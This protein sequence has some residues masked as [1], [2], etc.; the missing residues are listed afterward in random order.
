MTRADVGFGAV[1]Q[2]STFTSPLVADG[3]GPD[4]RRI[5]AVYHFHLP[6]VGECGG[7]SPGSSLQGEHQGLIFSTGF[8]AAV[9]SKSRQ[10]QLKEQNAVWGG[11]TPRH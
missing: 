2:R 5:S 1:S 4:Y 3:Y 6:C 9:D 11:A 7:V 10:A 8:E